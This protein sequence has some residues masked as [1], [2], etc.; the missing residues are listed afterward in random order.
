[1]AAQSAEALQAYK[2]LQQG[3]R[4]DLIGSSSIIVCK[5]ETDKTR[6]RRDADLHTYQNAA[7]AADNGNGV[8]ERGKGG[9]H[10]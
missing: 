3:A 6:A 5:H 4:R 7:D 8:G 10:R 9:Q 1:M 2:A